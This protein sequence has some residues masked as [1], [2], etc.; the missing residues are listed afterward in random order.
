MM[1]LIQQI[2]LILQ[3]MINICRILIKWKNNSQT[4]PV[5]EMKY[6]LLESNN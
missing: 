4:A 2:Y 3:K 6:K 5:I 1:D